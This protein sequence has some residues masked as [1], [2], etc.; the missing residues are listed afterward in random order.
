MLIPVTTLDTSQGFPKQYAYICR[1]TAPL[2][3]LM[4]L[5]VTVSTMNKILTLLF[6]VTLL[7]CS[8]SQFNS[9]DQDYS[10][11]FKRYREA[12]EQGD[13]H[14]QF[15]AGLAY[16]NGMG[17]TQS[18]HKAYKWFY[19][20]AEQGVSDAQSNLGWMYY[21]GQGCEKSI[22]EA[23]RWFH[24]AAEQGQT[25][26]M[27]NIGLMHVRGDGVLKS[28]V[29]AF[30]WFYKAAELGDSDAQIKIASMYMLGRGIPQN[31]QKAYVWSLVAT[32]SGDS[33]GAEIRSRAA[34][35]LT[36]SEI[37]AARKEADE[38]FKKING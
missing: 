4:F 17:V 10:E 31:P 1:Q 5:S 15:L 13:K 11:N 6:L 16:Y 21:N 22:I 26:A 32:A 19:K 24:R 29:E 7:G 35:E 34:P 12:A 37:S 3:R 2:C 28:Y 9:H 30:E 33:F 23:L 27:L 8:S 20:A 25:D 36:Q 14:G 18:Y 38:I